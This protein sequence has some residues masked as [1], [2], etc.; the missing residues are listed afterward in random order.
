MLFDFFNKKNKKRDKEVYGN[1]GEEWID[2][3]EYLIKNE[4][5]KVFLENLEQ[6]RNK[7]HMAHEKGRMINTLDFVTYAGLFL[8]LF[9][10]YNNDICIDAAKFLTMKESTENYNFRVIMSLVDSLSTKICS[11][12]EYMFQILN[13][14]FSLELNSMALNKEKIDNLYA[15]KME[16]VKEGD[17]IHIE[18]VDWTEE[19]KEKIASE[20]LKKKKVLNVGEKAKGIKKEIRNKGY[21]VSERFQK[22]SILYAQECVENM[23]KFVRNIVMHKK[24]ASFT[25]VIGEIDNLSPNEGINFNRSGWIEVNDFQK[26]LIEN[27]AVLKEALQIAYDI[28]CLGDKLVHI[29]NENKTYEIVLLECIN[30]KKNINMTDG[31]YELMLKMDGQVNCPECKNRMNYQSKGKTSEFEYNQVFYREVDMFFGKELSEEE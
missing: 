18:Y 27:I 3:K 19:E 5:E 13:H 30:C 11:C 7:F 12:W 8:E 31:L 4:D 2:Y 17:I 6:Y 16:F 15:K 28:V 1:F 29:G 9:N 10:Y 23:K 25:Y 20:V 26:M 24:S 22:I 21:V 14:Y